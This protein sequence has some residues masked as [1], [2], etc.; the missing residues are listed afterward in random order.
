VSRTNLIAEQS[1]LAKQ[2]AETRELIEIH[3]AAAREH[4]SLADEGSRRS[5]EASIQLEFLQRS[6][7]SESAVALQDAAAA[8]AATQQEI[9]RYEDYLRIFSR[10]DDTARETAQL[11][12]ER[13]I[14]LSELERTGAR[15]SEAEHRIQL[16]E[17]R[18][19]EILDRFQAPQFGSGV[20][21]LIDRSR[22][23]PIVNDRSFDQI[24]SLGLN[25][26]VNVAHALAHHLTCIELDR[27]LPQILLIDGLTSH[28]G[29]EGLDQTRV[30]AVYRYL[31]ELS[32]TMGPELQLIVVD[33]SVPATAR[34]YI[35]LELG[36]TNRLVPEEEPASN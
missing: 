25:V 19:S 3:R 9:R 5:R 1:R 30:E 32:E 34:P 8:R 20:R 31:I 29:H 23:L 21:A 4:E 11:E 36:D 13:G 2:I 10:V 16:L 7:I 6:F 33:N 28:I 26:L 35:R 17:K 27:P 14:L 12:E 24:L 18:F 22:F 15:Q